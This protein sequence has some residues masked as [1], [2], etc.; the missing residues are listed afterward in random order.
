[1]LDQAVLTIAFWLHMAAT[2][3]WIG[4]LFY[5]AV[6]VNPAL[7]RLPAERGRLAEDM[8][9]RFQ[10]LASLSLLVLIGTGLLQMSGN[11]NYEGLFAFTNPWS[12][13]LLTKHFAVGLMILVAAYQTWV[14]N[15][16]LSRLALKREADASHQVAREISRLNRVG[17]AFGIL[18]LGLTALARTA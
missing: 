12:R 14:L 8:R 15:P 18:V 16:R 7:E 9:R 4:G 10:P 6:V 2:I 1:M 11:P 5:Q 13:A 3:V 17:L